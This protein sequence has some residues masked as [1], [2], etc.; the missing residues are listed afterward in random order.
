[1]RLEQSFEVPVP[2]AQAWSVLLDLERIAPC[3]P[4]ATLTAFDGTAFTG[5]VKV[6]LGPVSLAYKGSGRFV[7]RDEAGQPGRARRLRPGQPRRRR[8]LGPGHRR[9]AR[10]QRWRRDPVKVV[11]DLDIAGKAA[12]FGRGHDR[13][14]LHQARSS[15]SPTAWPT[16]SRPPRWPPG[17]GRRR[18]RWPR[19]PPRRSPAAAG[20]TPSRRPARRRWPRCSPSRPRPTRRRPATNT[21]PT[22]PMSTRWPIPVRA[23]RGRHRSSRSRRRSRTS[24]RWSRPR[25]P[26]PDYAYSPEPGAGRVFAGTG[27][28]TGA[29]RS[30][31]G[32]ADRPA[33]RVRGQGHA[34]PGRSGADP[35]S[36]WRWSA[37]SSGSRS[38]ARASY[39]RG[40]GRAQY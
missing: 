23:A 20:A 17:R 22:R 14:R 10:G 38:R 9:A 24:R 32:R 29:R 16:R 37:S 19:S 28:R 8:S 26:S 4:G 34:A 11:A 21:N 31:G 15:S 33:R 6:K 5:T 30:T 1:M 13:R 36:R 3:M 2:V 7:E 39:A 35:V 27:P 12:Q 25:S 40:V 18:P